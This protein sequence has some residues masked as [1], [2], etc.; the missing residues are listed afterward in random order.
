MLPKASEN[1]P[2]IMMEGYR[3][4]HGDTFDSELYMHAPSSSARLNGRQKMSSRNQS[5]P[6]DD[7]SN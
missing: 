5:T 1:G 2:A 6:N 3:I 4:R 7:S